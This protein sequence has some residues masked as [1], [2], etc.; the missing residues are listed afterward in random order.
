MPLT[1][2][3]SALLRRLGLVSGLVALVFA[4]PVAAQ[5]LARATLRGQVTGT[6]GEPVA[7]AQV[8]L[9]DESSGEVVALEADPLGRFQL[10]FAQP[11][12]YS[13]RAEQGGYE[14]VIQHGIVLRPGEVRTLLVR[15]RVAPPPVL[16]VRELAAPAGNIARGINSGRFLGPAAIGLLNPRQDLAAL[17]GDFSTTIF[18]ADRP[19]WSLGSDGIPPRSGGLALDGVPHLALRHPGLPGEPVVL[20]L[21]A[22][23]RLGS[24]MALDNPVDP[25]WAGSPG[26]LASVQ[27]GH[28]GSRLSVRPWITYSGSRIGGRTEDNPADSSGLSL[29]A[30]AVVRGPLGRRGQFLLGGNYQTLERPTALPWTAD[31]ARYD[32]AI[33]DFRQTLD[34]VAADSFSRGVASYASPVLRTLR[35]GTGFGRFDFQPAPGHQLTLL[36]GYS[37]WKEQQPLLGEDLASGAATLLQ[38]RDFDASAQL[39]SQ[40]SDV[41]GNELRVGIQTSRRDWTSYGLPYTALVAEAAAIGTSPALPGLFNQ[42]AVDVGDAV[43]YRLG[44]HRLKL[45]GNATFTRYQEDYLYGRSGRFTFGNLDRFGMA[46]GAFFQTIGPDR[47]VGF[48]TTDIGLSVEDVWS[49]RPNFQ[50]LA[51]LRYSDQKLPQGVLAPDSA[52]FIASGI[53]NNVTPKDRNKFAPRAGFLWLPGG[54]NAWSI[55]GGIGWYYGGMDPA[56]L[57]EAIRYDGTV[58]VRRG[59]GGFSGWPAAPDSTAAPVVGPRLVL[60]SPRFRN[61][62]AFKASL[63]LSH[64]LARG[65][66]VELRGLY[67]HTDYLLRR[68]DLNL[69]P[70]PTGFTQEG[71]PVYGTLVQ[72]GGMLAAVPGSNRLISGFDLVSG[73]APTGYADYYAVSLSLTREVARGLSLTAAYTWSRTMD[74]TPLGRSG[75]PADQLSP[76]PQDPSS[77]EWV[78]GRSDLDVPHRVSVLGWYRTGGRL[79]LELGARY[80]FRSGLPFTPGF[81]PGVDANGDGSGA[82]DPAFVDPALAGM[83]PLIAAHACL[84]G[85][86]GEFASR[87]SCRDPSVHALDLQLALRLPAELGGLRLSVDAFNVVATAAGL[88]DHALVLVDPT[89]TLVTDANG[90]VTLPLVANPHFGELLSRR[91]L[92]RVVRF[93]LSLDY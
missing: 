47:T 44:R 63:N 41:Y 58:D 70:G 89:G 50:L 55:A 17:G 4:P 82:N 64:D 2:H 24:V 62:R 11:G 29:Q 93:G 30:G 83:G 20:P 60:F 28:G 91:T 19:G 69:L 10:D 77:A 73:L 23:D 66:G 57:A 85:Q 54:E 48:N 80:R 53:A 15:L 13:L 21:L 37:R 32:G 88:R 25:E 52:W 16:A 56:R 87:N 12:R 43:H 36:G 46:S 26:Q 59:L 34:V 39:T 3:A 75:D 8:T 78:D 84:D 90:D 51:G 68:S 74:N 27:S 5:S 61:P 14:P 67:S 79:G 6:G 49:L 18:P 31:T 7:M 71:R 33:V 40:L 35:G 72:Q 81:R 76:F 22:P 1:G 38:A 45:A 86:S 9:T 42:R 92:P 65:L